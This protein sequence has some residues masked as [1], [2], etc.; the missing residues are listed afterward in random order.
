[1]CATAES[2]RFRSD[3]AVAL[4]RAAD[5]DRLMALLEPLHLTVLVGGRLLALEARV[6]PRFEQQ[7]R[8]ATEVARQR[9]QAHEL[10]TLAILGTLERAGIRALPL[11]GSVLARDV[12]GDVASRSAGDIDILVAAPDLRG[13]IAAVEGM[14]WR[15][16]R[17]VS[18]NG[19]LPVLH[20][21][22]THPM[23]PR[24]ELHWR[25][26][27]YEDR[28]AADALTRAEQCVDH[29]PLRM[30]PAD[31]LAALTL[32][33]S[34]DGFSGLRMAADVAA[35]WDTMCFGQDVDQLVGAMA[36]EYPALAGPLL[37][38]TQL[39]GAL[40]ALP[41][42]PQAQP[43][44]WNVAAELATPFYEGGLVQVGTNASLIDL[45]LAPP[46]G[47]GASLRREIQKVPERVD[48]PLSR[49]DDLATHLARWGHALRLSRRWGLAFV[50]AAARAYRGHSDRSSVTT[51]GLS[52]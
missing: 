31:G 20:E 7:V 33:Y 44:R 26:H 30:R 47:S 45:L 12:H 32:V 13:A 35:W 5:T 42:R 25:V 4:M 48:R 36:A 43:F 23:M 37:V 46:S 6:E 3:E 51:A 14:D 10:M 39:L 21:T 2:R 1:M 52:R 41:T 24:V 49:H 27:W 38:G 50:P 28:F 15:W 22:L 16:Q 29:E 34:R 11:K 9:G 17:P 8:L 19:E 18:R 40:V